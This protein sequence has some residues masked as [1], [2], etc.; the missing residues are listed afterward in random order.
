M[1]TINFYLDKPDKKGCAPIHLR[2]N[3]NGSQ[4]KLS[5]GQKKDLARIMSYNRI[6]KGKVAIDPLYFDFLKKE[7]DLELRK[8]EY[9]DDAAIGLSMNLQLDLIG[10]KGAEATLFQ[11]AGAQKYFIDMIEGRDVWGSEY[12]PSKMEKR[13]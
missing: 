4:I 3:C 5:T 13:I 12:D 7:K 8:F 2:I 1:A 9:T 11:E 10:K 6:K